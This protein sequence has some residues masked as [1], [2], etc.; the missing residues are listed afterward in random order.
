VDIRTA[1][2][3]R[4]PWRP[5]WI[6]QQ[7]GHP[8][9]SWCQHAFL[10]CLGVPAAREWAL[11]NMVWAVKEYA[12]DYIMFDSNEWAVCDDPSHGHG[13]GDGEWAQTQGYYQVMRE[14]RKAFPDLMIMNSS[15]G[16]QR[17]DFGI[18]RWSNCVHP[19]DNATC[20]AKQR[21][22]QHGTGCMYPNSYQAS[23]V[24]HYTDV[25]TPDGYGAPLPA[26][27]TLSDERFEWRLLNRMMG[28]FGA[29]FEI[30][31]MAESQK[32]ILIKATAFFKRIR[33][34]T[35]GDRYVLAEPRV[36]YEPVYEES[37]NWEATQY[38]S[39]DKRMS[40]VYFY[41]CLSVE[42]ELTVK[43]RGLDPRGTYRV[44]WYSSRPARG[45]TGRELMEEGLTV[46]LERQRS[47]DIAVLTQE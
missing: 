46:R 37:D 32:Q 7:K 3:L 44:E 20:S 24:G 43:L 10:L 14:L 41:R 26:G 36:L 6:L 23:F 18:A 25:P 34:L 9:R 13:A 15:G 5:E 22:C 35:H 47:A 33:A 30:S 4:N 29:G 1:N 42:A 39:R 38:V 31:A 40:A 17:G 19:H 45:C 12:I 2:R 8:Y 16:S 21:R 28:Y 11:E 27:R